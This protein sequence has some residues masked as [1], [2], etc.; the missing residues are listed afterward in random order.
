MICDSSKFAYHLKCLEKEG[1]VEKKEQGYKL[2]IDG[3]RTIDHLTLASPQPL[4][5]VIIVVKR[6]DKVLVIEREKE[7]YKGT[8]EFCASKIYQ[9]ETL[10]EAAKDRIK[11][12]LGLTGEVIY[13]GIEFMQTKQDGELLMH[14]HLHIFLA[15][16]PE[17][18]AKIGE[19]VSIEPFGATHPLPQLHQVLKIIQ[20]PGFTIAV[21]D[22]IKE[23]DEYTKCVIHSFKNFW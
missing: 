21:T 15:E 23:G 8:Q 6:G 1:L 14:H 3:I 9:D 20:S 19:W 13:K 18:E 17:G 22:L 10:E 4:V 16:E 2:S 12:K 5:V 7:P 11:R